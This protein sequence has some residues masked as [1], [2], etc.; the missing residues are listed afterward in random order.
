[1]QLAGRHPRHL[2]RRQG[3]RQMAEAG[4][5]DKVLDSQPNP[6]ESRHTSMDS[7]TSQTPLRV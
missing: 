4:T 1:M 7:A 3:K 5:A 6:I 2:A